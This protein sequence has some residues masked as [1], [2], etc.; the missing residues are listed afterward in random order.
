MNWIN[1]KDKL[2]L[3]D[4]LVVVRLQ[5]GLGNGFVY[6]IAERRQAHKNGTWLTPESERNIEGNGFFVS[7]WADLYE[8][9]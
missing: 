7:D 1:V 5:D 8:L 2:P 3:F 9:D 6:E 4:C